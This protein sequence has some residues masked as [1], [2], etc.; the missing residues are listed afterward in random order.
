VDL[1]LLALRLK[2]D[3]QQKFAGVD[4]EGEEVSLQNKT[5]IH[6]EPILRSRVATPALK[7]LRVA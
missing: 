3:A 1:L 4:N 6:L 2:I 7:K 5:N